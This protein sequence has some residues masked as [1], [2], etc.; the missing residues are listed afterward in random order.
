MEP[1]RFYSHTKGGR[2]VIAQE[3]PYESVDEDSSDGEVLY[4]PN[5][6]SDTSDDSESDFRAEVAEGLLK[7]KK[8]T[9]RNKKSRRS[10]SDVEKKL[11]AKKKKGRVALNPSKGYS[12]GQCWTLAHPF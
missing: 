10:S 3:L 5:E 11:L 9:T 8:D 4:Q 7:C 12:D 6:E 1:S 2:S